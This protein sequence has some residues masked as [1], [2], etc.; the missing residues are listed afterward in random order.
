MNL[1]NFDAEAA[2][3]TA[4]DIKPCFKWEEQRFIQFAFENGENKNVLCNNCSI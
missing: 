2:E 4:F 1:F 3:A